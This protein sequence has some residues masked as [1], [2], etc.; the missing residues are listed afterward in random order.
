MPVCWSDRDHHLFPFVELPAKRTGIHR[1][2]SL[3]TVR[4]GWSIDS[5]EACDAQLPRFAVF[6]ATLLVDNRV[7]GWCCLPA[8]IVAPMASEDRDALLVAIA[9]SKVPPALTA[10]PPKK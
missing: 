1:V 2:P 7:P 3:C 9:C 8:T 5:R 4:F 6:G 10:P